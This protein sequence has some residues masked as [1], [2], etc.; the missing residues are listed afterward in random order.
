M[1]L[2]D[3]SGLKDLAKKMKKEEKVAQKTVAAVKPLAKPVRFVCPVLI[4]LV[5]LNQLGLLEGIL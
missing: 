2:N 3:L 1:K 5:F 4:L